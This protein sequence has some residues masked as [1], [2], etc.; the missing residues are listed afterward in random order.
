MSGTEQWQPGDVV[1]AADLR[2][3]SRASPPGPPW[4]QVGSVCYVSEDVPVRPLTL[5]VRDSKPVTDRTC[6][7]CGEGDLYPR[8]CSQCGQRWVDPACGLT[9]AL[10]A[11]ELGLTA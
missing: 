8:R 1:L 5:L 4:W 7:R 6:T 3:W 9:H 10:I 11:H 2:L